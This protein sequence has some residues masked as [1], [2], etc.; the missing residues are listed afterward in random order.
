MLDVPDAVLHTYE[1]KRGEYPFYVV[2]KRMGGRYYLYRQTS[3]WDKEKKKVR[4]LAEYLGRIATDGTF[5]E[6]SIA[7]KEPDGTHATYQ[8]AP[9]AFENTDFDEIDK[10][11]LTILSMNGRADLAYWA[12]RMGVSEQL[13]YYKVKQLERRL[14]IRYLAEINV[15]KLGYLKIFIMVKF[16]KKIPKKEEITEALKAEP[17]VQLAFLTKGDYDLMI[18]ALVKNISGWETIDTIVKLRK[19][20]LIRYPARWYATVFYEHFGF[21]PIRGEFIDLLKD[22]IMK[23]EYAVLKELN[24]NGIQEFTAIDRKYGFDAGRAGYTYHKLRE[25]QTIKRVTIT[26]Q[27][28]PIRYVGVIA[29]EMVEEV[30]FRAKRAKLLSDI[31]ER[32][33]SLTNK[34]ALTGDVANPDGYL[35]F[36]PVL[37]EGA[38]SQAFE[39]IAKLN[40]GVDLKTSIITE[41]LVG[42]F[43][44]RL[45]DISYARQYSLLVEEY[46]LKAEKRTDYE[47]TDRKKVAISLSRGQDHQ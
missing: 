32:T 26:M 7:R 10:K 11:L 41:I 37:Q 29:N 34:Y 25:N 27:R 28:L 20:L 40:L 8:R 3:K 45:F 30:K 47:G 6:K 18:Y 42:S 1:L 35:F 14:G 23:R 44:Y 21:V 24:D 16:T 46:G 17:R 33:G 36:L 2:L 5:I 9:V 15:E 4:T 13:A 38:L 12:R 43:C 22:S 39:K 31:I 19:G